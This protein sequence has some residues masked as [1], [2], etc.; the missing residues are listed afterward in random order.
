MRGERD[1]PQIEEVN[2]SNARVVTIDFMGFPR[3]VRSEST[4]EDP[5]ASRIEQ[6]R[7]VTA[8]ADL[9]GAR[10]NLWEKR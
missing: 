8:G 1:C 10:E 3:D 9:G 6:S 2:R 7:C 4:E 5:V